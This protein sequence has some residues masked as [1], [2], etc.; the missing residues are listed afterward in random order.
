LVIIY[1]TIGIY[2]HYIDDSWTLKKQLVDFKVL[3]GSH[4][5]EMLALA[6]WESLGALNLQN[7]LLAVTTDN[8]SNNDSLVVNLEQ[9]SVTESREGQFQLAWSHVRCLAHINENTDPQLF[10]GILKG[11]SKLIKY[12]DKACVVTTLST[13]LDPRKN[14]EY[15]DVLNWNEDWTADVKNQLL[16][17]FNHYRLQAMQEVPELPLHLALPDVG[18]E[19]SR[20]RTF[21]SSK[22]QKQPLAV[23]NEL[24]EYLGL[25]CVDDSVE[26]LDW[27]RL[28][29]HTYPVL[30]AMAKDYLAVQATSVACEQ[31]FS[32]GVDLVTPDRN[33]LNEDT[34]TECMSLKK[35][36][37]SKK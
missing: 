17:A 7:K 18:R 34:I 5:G 15:F 36:W 19:N 25:S 23:K 30:A 6:F 27:W 26:P 2:A 4:S 9:L 37:A 24:H 8:A 31:L 3:N 10:A 14:L 20:L 13:V 33:R 32:G 16:E 28:N 35:W 12:Y 21:K 29:Q 22:R 1:L 11:H